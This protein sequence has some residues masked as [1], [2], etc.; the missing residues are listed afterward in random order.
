MHQEPTVNSRHDTLLLINEISFFGINKEDSA[1]RVDLGDE[2]VY[3]N[4]LDECNQLIRSG[5][6]ELISYI[7]ELWQ[8]L[9]RTA[10]ILIE[11]TSGN[12]S[13][14]DNIIFLNSAK[15]SYYLSRRFSELS[16]ISQT[17]LLLL[18]S[19]IKDVHPDLIQKF[20]HTYISI[21]CVH[22]LILTQIYRLKLIK[23]LSLLN[24][25][26]QIAG[27]WANIDLP[28][29]E[30]AWSFADDEEYLHGRSRARR[31][32]TR[33]N[34]ETNEAGF[35]YVFQDRNRDPYLFED[36]K[37]ESPYPSNPAARIP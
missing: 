5:L 27:P 33:Y 32:Q 14:L 29:S 22:Q 7:F 19:D 28:M 15:K 11:N 36:Y 18:N 9:N 2:E 16:S 25:T 12:H 34:P 10:L 35:Y 31:E 24:K 26:A 6:K 17:L 1:Y 30:R 13:I 23:Q 8:D 37:D 21:K 3:V 20:N 4:S